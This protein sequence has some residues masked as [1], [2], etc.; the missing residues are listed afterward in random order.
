MSDAAVLPPSTEQV[1]A[2]SLLDALSVAAAVL[3]PDGQWRQANPALGA[4]LG[5]A[6][7]TLQGNPAHRHHFA[8]ADAARIDAAL[9]GD[10]TGLR[11]LPL[12]LDGGTGQPRHC[13]LDLQALVPDGDLLLQLRDVTALH[14]LEQVQETLAFGISHELRAP[15][16][17]IEQFSR[18]LADRG[19]TLEPDAAL[20][21]LQRIRAAAGQAGG[22]IDGLLETMRASRPPR[23]PGPVDISLLGDW[24]C[25]EL[26]D[27]APTRA[28]DV[29]VAPDLWA[30]GDEHALKQLL[31]KLLDNAWRFSAHRD[32]VR[33]ELDGER[34]GDRM[35]LRLRDGGRGFDMR[36]ADR[37]FV[38]FK[39][40]HGADDGA[41]HGLGLAI[42][43]RIA[44]A[45]GGHIR[46]QSE[47]DIGTTFTIE[48]PA[49]PDEDAA[50]P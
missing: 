8:E 36:Y 10:G 48:L 5:V 28:A 34:V 22:L 7:D 40:L 26:Q 14:A 47:P 17:A 16:R 1:T 33:I 24:I 37:L 19:A 6:P 27:A 25:A 12:V 11:D 21:H 29:Q 20:D 41:G 18:R 3:A 23:A 38:P 42:A 9:A 44:Q 46:V 2:A 43:Q 32:R 49:V 4:L 35:Q 31:G 13:L 39:R 30:W 15:V 45:H 50:R